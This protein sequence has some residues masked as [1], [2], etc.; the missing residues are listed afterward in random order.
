MNRCFSLNNV[1]QKEIDTLTIN[2]VFLNDHDYINN[3]CEK[4]GFCHLYDTSANNSILEH[5]MSHTPIIINKLPATIEY[6]GEDYPMF[7]E[8]I[9]ENPDKYLLSKDFVQKTSDYLKER[10]KNE[11]FKSPV[12]K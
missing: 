1:N 11:I 8:N 2:H 7:Y 4:I 12:V 3:L 10:S 9:M 6:L 5:I